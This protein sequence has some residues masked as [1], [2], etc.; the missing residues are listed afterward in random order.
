MSP[1]IIF[2]VIVL[3]V[4]AAGFLSRKPMRAALVRKVARSFVDVFCA[5]YAQRHI[6]Q[7]GVFA[8]G[9]KDTEI[10]Y[11][12]RQILLEACDC[13]HVGDTENISMR[14][15][16]PGGGMFQ[17]YFVNAR[18]DTC[19]SLIHIFAKKGKRSELIHAIGATT[20]FNTGTVISSVA[21][22]ND[23]LNGS[24]ENMP[25]Q[26]I[27]NYLPFD[28]NCQDFLQKHAHEVDLYLDNREGSSCEVAEDM[29]SILRFANEKQKLIH[30]HIWSQGDLVSEDHLR[31]HLDQR[32]HPMVADI[33][34]EV[35]RLLAECEDV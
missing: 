10:F 12:E 16:L 17:K 25:S 20:Y 28:M 13:R 23:V 32:M 26:I 4:L 3:A 7:R 11:N 8:V 19:I 21:S 35:D 31:A 6:Y 30:D 27:I 22:D 14:P 15:V 5:H 24:A 34:R 18:A 2:S 1:E 33:K 29:E 9:N